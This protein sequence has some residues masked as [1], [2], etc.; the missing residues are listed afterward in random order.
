MVTSNNITKNV[1]IVGIVSWGKGC[2]QENFPGSYANVKMYKEFIEKTIKSGECTRTDTG[3]FDER[4]LE[5]PV[6]PDC[7]SNQENLKLAKCNKLASKVNEIEPVT[8]PK[9]ITPIGPVGRLGNTSNAVNSTTLEITTRPSIEDVG[10]TTLIIPTEQSEPTANPT[11]PVSPFEVLSPTQVAIIIDTANSTTT[12]I[13]AATEHTITTTPVTVSNPEAPTT[14]PINTGSPG[15]A[16]TAVTKGTPAY[17]TT[18]ELLSSPAYSN[19]QGNRT[20][21]KNQT[22][23]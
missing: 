16:N 1:E 13:T 10:S 9:P 21:D 6:D 5:E 22:R 7:K 11:E 17:V 23:I 19:I 18:M 3:I 14:L 4:T 20:T 8:I 12:V 15:T 2:A